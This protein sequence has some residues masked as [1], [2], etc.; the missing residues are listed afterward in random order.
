[1][2]LQ[3]VLAAKWRHMRQMV[4]RYIVRCNMNEQ[5]FI[6]ALQAELKKHSAGVIE[7]WKKVLSILPD[8]TKAVEVITTFF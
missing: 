7:K 5:E 1:M 8:E 6:N 3:G 2:V 4:R